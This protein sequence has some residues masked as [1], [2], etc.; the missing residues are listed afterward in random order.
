MVVEIDHPVAG[1]YKTAGNP[2]K[3]GEP[4]NFG[5]PPTLGQDTEAVLGDL[6]GYS[7]TAIRALR[8]ANAA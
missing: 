6:L 3:S 5:P 1:T 2:I 7:S 8:D 4:E